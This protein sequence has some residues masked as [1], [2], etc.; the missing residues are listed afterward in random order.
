VKPNLDLLANKAPVLHTLAAPLAGDILVVDIPV[1][2]VVE[3][4]V[5]PEL[6]GARF[7]YPM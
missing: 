3:D 1:V 4:L 5:S 7:M 6:A 2:E